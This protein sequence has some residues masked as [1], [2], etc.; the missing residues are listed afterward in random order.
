MMYVCVCIYDVCMCMY[1][2]V[3]VNIHILYKLSYL[4]DLDVLRIVS[5]FLLFRCGFGS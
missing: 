3:Y 4:N 1:A 2:Y 5:G